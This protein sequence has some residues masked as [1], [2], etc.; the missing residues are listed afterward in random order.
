[1][2][3]Q[4]LTAELKQM[5][6]KNKRESNASDCAGSK[7]QEIVNDI[8]ESCSIS[9]NILNDLLLIDKIEEGNLVLEMKPENAKALFEPCINNFGVQVQYVEYSDTVC[10]CH[11][12]VFTTTIFTCRRI[13][14]YILVLSRLYT[15]RHCILTSIC[16]WTCKL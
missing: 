16:R 12:I 8:S 15:Y 5:I 3:I 6:D 1:M 7:L 2:G 4:L 13:D 11:Q 14:S 10:S 9:V